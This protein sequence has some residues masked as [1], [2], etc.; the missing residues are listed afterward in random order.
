MS[1]DDEFEEPFYAPNRPS[2]GPRQPT[3]GFEQ[4]RLTDGKRVIVCEFRDA[5]WGCHMPQSP[6]LL[7]KFQ[8]SQNRPKISTNRKIRVSS[9]DCWKRSF[10]TAP[11]PPEVFLLVTL[12]RA[13]CSCAGT[14]VEIGGEGGIRTHVPVTRQD[15]FEAPPLRPLRYLSA[16]L[17]SV[18][19]TFHYSLSA[20]RGRTPASARGS[21][22]RAR[23]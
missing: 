4:W 16:R 5:W 17:A 13:T 11:S 10:R 19:R 18:K 14:K 23:R 7:K 21:R 3:P 8:N 6:S 2:E 12:S 9:A 20:A 1:D 22:T 15:A